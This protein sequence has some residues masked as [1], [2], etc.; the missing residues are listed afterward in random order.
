MDP[1]LRRHACGCW[2]LVHSG[3]GVHHSHSF[4][5]SCD[6]AIERDSSHVLNC[7]DQRFTMERCVVDSKNRLFPFCV[8][9][10]PISFI[11]WLFPLCGHVGIGDSQGIV[12]DFVGSYRLESGTYFF[13]GESLENIW[14]DAIQ[15][16]TGIFKRKTHT[17]IGTNCHT[18]VNAVLNDIDGPIKH[19][20]TPKLIWNVFTKGTYIGLS[21]VIRTW[22]P[23]VL[24][25]SIIAIASIIFK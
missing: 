15:K 6:Q 4:K 14:D 17:L 8:V 2:P 13:V 24:I 23:F 18:Y 11:S 1:E 19:W 22:M 10:T 20:G 21:G 9:W 5:C 7:A 25:I 3:L 12:H 16:E